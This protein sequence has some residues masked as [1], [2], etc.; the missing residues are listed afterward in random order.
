MTLCELFTMRVPML[1]SFELGSM[2]EP[3]K[4]DFMF[5][6]R[7]AHQKQRPRREQHSVLTF[8]D[9]ATSL[10][11]Y[12]HALLKYA[13]LDNL[14]LSCDGPYACIFNSEWLEM[15]GEPEVFGPLPRNT[16]RIA[17]AY[18]FVH[19]P[20][21]KDVNIVCCHSPNSKNWRDLKKVGTR[22]T[23]F[24]NCVSRAGGTKDNRDPKRWVVCGDLNTDP[25][26]LQRLSSIYWANNATPCADDDPL[27]LRVEVT[28][29]HLSM[30]NGDCTVSQGLFLVP[31]QSDTREASDAHYMVF[32]NGLTPADSLRTAN[33][34]IRN[35]KLGREHKQCM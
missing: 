9:R 5:S 2:K 8:C 1:F 25:G 26:L 22:N 7:A 6:T 11:E 21:A 4:I 28:T 12:M 17:M 18:A 15:D 13:G 10:H 29:H 34:R 14:Q 33:I 16:K 23:I 3:N 35:E 24:Q 30:E 27:A 32:L 19:K 20:T 31:D